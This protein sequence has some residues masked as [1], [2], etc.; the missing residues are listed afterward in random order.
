MEIFMFL[1]LVVHLNINVPKAKKLKCRIYNLKFTSYKEFL[2]E[3]STS[4]SSVSYCLNRF[5][6][7]VLY[8]FLFVT[9]CNQNFRFFNLIIFEI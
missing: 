3:G 2:N 5:K 1:K 9:I 7:V 6:Q 4:H 8:S